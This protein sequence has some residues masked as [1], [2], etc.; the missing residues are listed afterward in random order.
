MQYLNILETDVSL[1][2]LINEVTSTQSEVVITRHGLPIAKIS[3]CQITP[4]TNHYPLRGTPITI[5]D[6][7]D[8]SMPELWEALAE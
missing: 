4:K 1:N 5:S 3:P 2:A 6:D 7:F 8:E